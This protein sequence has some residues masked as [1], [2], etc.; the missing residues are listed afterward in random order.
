MPIRHKYN[1]HL[2][3][4]SCTVLLN[5]STNV[6]TA[7]LHNML[8]TTVLG[9][10]IDGKGVPGLKPSQTHH[11][12]QFFLFIVGS[13]YTVLGW[14]TYSSLPRWSGQL[15]KIFSLVITWGRT[16]GTASWWLKWY[17]CCLVEQ[18]RSD[19]LCAKLGFLCSSRHQSLPT[20]SKV[21]GA[22]GLCLS[23]WSLP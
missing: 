6:L 4:N 15:W 2:Q 10:P 11:L 19:P 5:H 20:L 16:T 22:H 12:L 1:L 14:G 23:P 9:I 3:Y 21:S 17:C 7:G 8:T 13:L 18:S